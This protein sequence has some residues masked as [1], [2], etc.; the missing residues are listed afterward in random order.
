MKD[1]P[2][3]L[4]ITFVLKFDFGEKVVFLLAVILRIIGPVLLELLMILRC[5][6]FVFLRIEMV[7]D[8]VDFAK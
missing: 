8:G 1:L 6:S 3:L 5:L 2:D 7:H 4:C